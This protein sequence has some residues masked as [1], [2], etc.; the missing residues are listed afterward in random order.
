MTAK[1]SR[2]VSQH[3]YTKA[4]ALSLMV[5]STVALGGCTQNEKSRN[6]INNTAAQTRVSLENVTSQ[7]DT[8]KFNPLVV[9][10]KLWLGDVA[11]RIHRGIPLPGKYESDHGITLVSADPMTLSDIGA[12]ISSQTGI[13]VRISDM[14]AG[15]LQQGGAQRAAAPSSSQSMPIAYEGSLSGLLERVAGNFG[16]SW[17]YDGGTINVSRYETRVFVVEALPGTQKTSVDMQG[18]T[19][20]GSTS[21]G[22]SG[23]GGGGG[24]SSSSGGA[25]GGTATAGGSAS[26]TSSMSSK[27]EVDIKYWDELKE[28]LTA[29]V[30]SNGGI[31]LSPSLGTVTVTTTPEIMRSIASYLSQENERMTRQIAVNVEVYN[32]ALTKNEDFNLTFSAFLHQ[33]NGITLSGAAVP[34]SVGQLA[35]LASASVAVIDQAPGHTNMSNVFNALSTIGDTTRVARFPIVTLNNRPVAVRI[36]HDIGYVEKTEATS[37]STT[38]SSSATNVTVTP[39]QINEGFSIQLAPR[40]LDDGRILMQYSLTSVDLDNLTTF[41]SQ[42]GVS[43]TCTPGTSS[44]TI[45]LPTTTNRSYNQQSVLR[46]GSMLVIGGVNEKKVNQNSSGVGSPFNFIFGGGTS[47]GDT[48]TMMLI[49]ITPQVIDLPQAEHG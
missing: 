28:I 27:S 39:G 10:D 26:S 15:V 36:G 24:S 29:M 32:L 31:V 48:D 42:C 8:Q 25:G 7:G 3:Q 49:A 18:G 40:L 35:G 16:V 38:T 12:A 21:S 23:G 6:Q 2:R 20:S 1:I 43:T 34:T 46:S 17:N 13:S 5:L 22:G 41:N 33:L 14:N 9:T 30:G 44:S 19:S 4:C 45:Q 11:L 47:S 37:S